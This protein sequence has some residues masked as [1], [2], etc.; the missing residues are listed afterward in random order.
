MKI[1]GEEPASAPFQSHRDIARHAVWKADNL[2]SELVAARFE[3]LVPQLKNLFRDAGEGFLPAR[4]LLING[5]AAVSAQPV[6]E[7]IHLDLALTVVDGA[8][9]HFCRPP[10]TLFIRNSGWFRQMIEQRLF[11]ALG[12]RVPAGL[13][14]SFICLRQRKLFHE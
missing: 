5:A 7:T 1:A 6:R 11:F 10:D 2:G 4:F 12:L 14:G 9:D 13:L 8:L 3:V